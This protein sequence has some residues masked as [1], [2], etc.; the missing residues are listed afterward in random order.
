[1]LSRINEEALKK[2]REE[3][4]FPLVGALLKNEQDLDLLRYL[5]R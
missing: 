5:K 1:M 3:G 2:A 4:R